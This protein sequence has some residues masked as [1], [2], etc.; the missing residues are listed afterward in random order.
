MKKAKITL[1]QLRKSKVWH[2][3]TTRIPK[4][5]QAQKKAVKKGLDKSSMFL[6]MVIFRYGVK[7]VPEFRFDP[8]RRWRFD[9][10][11]PHYKIAIEV[12]GGVWT[13]GRHTR[14]SGFVKDIEKYNRAAAL[15]WRLVRV[16]PSDLLKDE[17][18]ELVGEMINNE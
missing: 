1:S 15:G 12:E 18:L 8:N 10:A 13:Q 5:P 17:F 11:L 3:N 7:I 9:F 4:R 6:K 2:K 16:V 14:G